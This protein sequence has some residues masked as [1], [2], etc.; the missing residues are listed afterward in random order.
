MGMTGGKESNLEKIA[1]KLDRD[2]ERIPPRKSWAALKP[3]ARS[4]E[5]A[6]EYHPELVRK[7]IAYSLKMAAKILPT[8]FW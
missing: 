6:V 1:V 2:K 5:R 3:R 8:K 7:A 4:W